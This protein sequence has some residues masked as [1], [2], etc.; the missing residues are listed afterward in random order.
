M[1][2]TVSTL[3]IILLGGFITYDHKEY[4]VDN[5][6]YV[7]NSPAEFVLNANVPEQDTIETFESD[8]Y[9]KIYLLA[10]TEANYGYRHIL[11]R[12][13][14]EY[15]V[16]FDNKNGAT[17]FDD[18][19]GG[20]DILL[21]IKSFY[22]HCVDVEAYNRRTDRNITYVGYTEL[23]KKKIKCLLVVRKKDKGI[24]TFYPFNEMSAEEL[25]RPKQRFHYD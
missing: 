22:N 9:G 24:V 7:L 14:S 19:V 4:I 10:G 13:T 20:N 6:K 17:L 5:T 15:F 25:I 8:I 3:L 21:G 23:N 18:E 1:Q 16:N 12:H 2:K 11:A